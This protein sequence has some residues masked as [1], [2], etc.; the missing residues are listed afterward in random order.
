MSITEED[1][2]KA[3]DAEDGGGGTYSLRKFFS[4][5]PASLKRWILM[6]VTAV[7]TIKHFD[8]DPASVAIGGLVLEGTLDLF[9]VQ[10]KQKVKEE[11]AAIKGIALGQQT[12]RRPIRAADHKE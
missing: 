12:A 8:I 5:S 4:Q 1:L 3:K 10:P 2:N 7:I 11:I 9:Y 6:V